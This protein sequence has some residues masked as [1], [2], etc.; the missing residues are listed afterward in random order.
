MQPTSRVVRNSIGDLVTDRNP[1]QGGLGLG[2]GGKIGSSLEI[3]GF[4]RQCQG[5]LD[6]IFGEVV[7]DWVSKSS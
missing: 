4:N 3:R 6:S 5:L 1:Y 7:R 2:V